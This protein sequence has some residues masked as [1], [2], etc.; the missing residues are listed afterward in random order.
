MVPPTAK[1]PGRLRLSVEAV[2][3]WQEM[4]SDNRRLQLSWGQE[5]QP[6]IMASVVGRVACHCM[7]NQ[8]H[9]ELTELMLLF[10]T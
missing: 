5:T 7:D 9:Q 6:Q 8:K 2:G 10:P 3:V 1:D 4:G